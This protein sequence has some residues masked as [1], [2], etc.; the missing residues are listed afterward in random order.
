[1]CSIGCALGP[2]LFVIILACAHGEH[3][4]VFVRLVIVRCVRLAFVYHFYLSQVVTGSI[5]DDFPSA[6]CLRAFVTS[7]WRLLWASFIR[8][9]GAHMEWGPW[10]VCCK[11]D[12]CPLDVWLV[13]IISSGRVIYLT[14]LHSC[15]PLKLQSTNMIEGALP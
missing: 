4:L 3:W 7:L 10:L 11:V 5:T 1:M 6:L 14:I 2:Y 9:G 13:M 12:A 8:N 15:A